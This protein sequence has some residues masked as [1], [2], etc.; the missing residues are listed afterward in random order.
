MKTL[1][2]N[3]IIAVIAI[4]GASTP[5]FSQNSDEDNNSRSLSIG[6]GF[7]DYSKPF[8]AEIG[9]GIGPF[10]EYEGSDDYAATALP[11]INIRKPGAYFIRGASI[12]TNNGL[13]SAGL[14]L[15]H[16]SFSEE[17]RR[18]MQIVMGPLIRA[19]GG[20]DESDSDVLSGLGD[21][22]RSA[23]IGGFIEFTAGDW[24]ANLSVSPQ[25]V[26]NDNDGT[27]ATFDIAYTASIK[28]GLE[29]STG[30]ST[31]WANDDYMQ[32]YFGVTDAQAVKSGL[33]RFDSKSGFKDV[34]LQVKAT[35]AVS[36]RWSL[37]GQVGYW[38]L[39]NDAADS[40]I[41]KD[42]GSADQVRGLVGLS[43]QF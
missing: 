39:L 31:S 18:R 25:D 40:P 29:L 11:L 24:L 14:S 22:D 35:Y 1:H 30:L 26:G 3:T 16:F 38:H 41:V 32:S 28:D 19:Y 15:L 20:R 23:G 4:I 9:L 12:N 43:Y 8:Q 17:S 36:P 13:A 37:E 5:A 7:P 6:I 27:L 2:N 33:S 10:P 34:G 42:E 21:I